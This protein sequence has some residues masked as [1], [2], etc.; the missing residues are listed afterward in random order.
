MKFYKKQLFLTA[1]GVVCLFLTA[2]DKQKPVLT[3]QREAFIALETRQQP[4]PVLAQHVVAIPAGVANSSWPQMAGNPAHAMPVLKLA[5]D[6]KSQGS[7]SLGRGA[8]DCQRLLSMVVAENGRIY[9]MD[10]D[11]L[12]TA[13]DTAKTPFAVVWQKPT[14]PSDIYQE[15]LGGGVSVQKGIVY[16]STSF[17]ELVA[18]DEKEGRE[19]WRSSVHSPVRTAPT[20]K[21]GRVFV[22]TIS[23]ETFAFDATTGTHLWSHAGIAEQSALLGGGSPAVSEN[24]VIVAYSSGEVYAL[25]AENGHVLWS[26]TLTSAVRVDTVSSI[27]HI[28]AC[29]VV[30]GGQVFVISHGGRIVSIDL[31]TGVRQWQ[32][33][34][35]GT[36]APVVA[37]DWLFVLSGQGDVFCL[38][39]HTG[40]IR[41]A[42]ALPKIDSDDSDKKTIF[43]SGPVLIE[44]QLVFSGSNGQVRFIHVKD[45]QM[46]KVLTFSGQSFLPPIVVNQTLYILNDQA[47]LYA[48][49]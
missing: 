33:E 27:P 45:G 48:W 22:T 30:E 2:C 26:D 13:I 6:P 46:A 40:A 12:V 38:Q 36:H 14:T 43:W 8:T 41:W 10:A 21:D 17:G 18:F 4:D 9:G 29:P 35:G 31:K 24:V 42:A 20:V 3:G 7:I 11:G 25:Q 32:R 5:P 39:R 19:L 28:R 37:G 47:E 16:A 15:A 49:K 1:A 44:D 23:N 34:I